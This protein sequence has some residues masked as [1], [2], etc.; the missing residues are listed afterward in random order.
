[1]EYAATRAGTALV[2]PGLSIALNLSHVTKQLQT[3]RHV[4]SSLVSLFS[5]E[6]SIAEDVTIVKYV[7]KPVVVDA[8]DCDGVIVHSLVLLY[9]R[10]D[11]SELNIAVADAVWDVYLPI[12]S[13]RRWVLQ[14]VVAQERG[15]R[16]GAPVFS[17]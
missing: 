15:C 17:F 1:M 14:V 6:E 16:F 2:P 10:D 13:S 9:C 8:Y 11:G 3:G 4:T 12:D 7:V 5:F